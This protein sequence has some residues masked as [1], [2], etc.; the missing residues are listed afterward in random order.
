L[1]QFGVGRKVLQIKYRLVIFYNFHITL[2]WIHW[3]WTVWDHTNDDMQ[4]HC[5]KP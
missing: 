3:S 4:T 1:G 2:H 5:M